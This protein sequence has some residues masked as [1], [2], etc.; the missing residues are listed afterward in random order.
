MDDGGLQNAPSLP[1][2]GSYFSQLA[3]PAPDRRCRFCWRGVYRELVSSKVTAD[4][5]PTLSSRALGA[6]GRSTERTTTRRTHLEGEAAAGG[7]PVT[8]VIRCRAANFAKGP[9][10]LAY[11]RCGLP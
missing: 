2:A 4:Q 3:L 5:R 7:R 6:L 11:R 10:F 8:N 1:R 9:G